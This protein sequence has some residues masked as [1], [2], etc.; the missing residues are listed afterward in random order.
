ML[1]WG[2]LAWWRREGR[3]LHDTVVLSSGMLVAQAVMLLVAPIWSRLYSPTDFGLFGLWTAVSSI[4]SMLLTLRLE[5]GIVVSQDDVHARTLAQVCLWLACTCATALILLTLAVPR[6]WIQVV[7]LDSL[8]FL[9]Q[10]AVIG[11]ALSA[12]LG[13]LQSVANRNSNYRWMSLSRGG[14]GLVTAF[15]GVILGFVGVGSGLVV[16]QLV[17][18]AVGLLVIML[19]LGKGFRFWAPSVGFAQVRK[20]IHEHADAPRFLWPAAL[21]DV[22]TQQLPL[23]LIAKLYEHELVGYFSLAWRVIAVPLFM[24]SGAAG[25]V[26]FQRMSACSDKPHE[27]RELLLKS[28]RTF[29]LLGAVPC[30][31]LLLWGKP[32]FGWV[33]GSEWESAGGMASVMAPMLW[34]MFISSATSTSLIVLRLQKWAP[35]FGLAMLVYRPLAFWI[36]AR[37][38]SLELALW[39]WVLTEIVVVALYN[40]LIL[41]KLRF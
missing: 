14:G 7:G 21:L 11:G 38:S 17:A 19:G 32:I 18:V 2:R 39:I 40:L 10:L 22:L 16:S 37:S 35:I 31:L 29:A 23:L 3:L 25:S 20:T 5:T 4:V 41:R 27:M 36:G 33:F 9:L 8:G 12:A 15:G 1:N 34:V 6:H 24:I 13:T 26:F 28:W 30:T